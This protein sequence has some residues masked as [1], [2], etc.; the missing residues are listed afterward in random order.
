MGL[1]TETQDSVLEVVP[2]NTNGTKVK[3]YNLTIEHA[4]CFY[5]NGILVGNCDSAAQ[6]SH[7]P[8]IATKVWKPLEENKNIIKSVTVGRYGER[9]TKSSSCG[10]YI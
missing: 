1:D 10:R 9:L 6:H 8:I 7:L 2:Q 4:H 3:V 5:A